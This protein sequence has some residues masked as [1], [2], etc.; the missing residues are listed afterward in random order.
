MD[1]YEDEL[2]KNWNNY[3]RVMKKERPK[4][5]DSEIE[6]N[7]RKFYDKNNPPFIASI[8]KVSDTL[9]QNLQLIQAD[10]EIIDNRQTFFHPNYFHITL[11]EFG[12]Q[13]QV[14]IKLISG[15]MRNLTNNISPF[16]LEIRG[17]NCFER[18]VYA[19]VF[20]KKRNLEAIFN[21]CIQT[22][23]G[24]KKNFPSYIPHIS[25]IKIDTTEARDMIEVIE[26]KY[27]N[28][29]IGKILV[30]E[31]QIVAARPYLTAGR[32]VTF[33]KIQLG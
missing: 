14:E 30:K 32:I 11:N 2:A 19:Q 31:I 8:V 1:T 23:P 18:I 4:F 29:E 7:G 15:K 28:I 17:I 12:W 20:D 5:V 3:S 27:R 33:E 16:E 22:F 21:K 9:W 26:K 6:Y 10:L 25:L 24:L 13:D